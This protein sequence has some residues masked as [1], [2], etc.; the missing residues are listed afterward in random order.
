MAGEPVAEC[1]TKIL[2]AAEAKATQADDRVKL[3]VAL[4]VAL[5]NFISA[6]R[7]ENAVPGTYRKVGFP[8]MYLAGDQGR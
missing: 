3:Q 5:E 4:G 2:A 8:M 1:M 7:E 6:T